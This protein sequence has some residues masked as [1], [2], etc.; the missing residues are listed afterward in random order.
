MLT[1]AVC[2][3]VCATQARNLLKKTT[4]GGKLADG[5]ELFFGFG[6]HEI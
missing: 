1:E 4:N 3:C 2:V 6:D 5:G